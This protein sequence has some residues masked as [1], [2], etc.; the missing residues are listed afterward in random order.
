MYRETYFTADGYRG[1][2]VLARDGASGRIRKPDRSVRSRVLY[3]VELRDANG[4]EAGIQNPGCKAFDR[5]PQQ[6]APSASRGHL[7]HTPYEC[8]G[9][10]CSASSSPRGYYYFWDL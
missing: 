7:T 6:G 9:R 3:P 4:G 5:I 10:T 2:A 8:F 1:K